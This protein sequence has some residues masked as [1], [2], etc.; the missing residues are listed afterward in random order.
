MTD[1]YKIIDDVYHHPIIGYGSIKSVYKESKSINKYITVNDVKDYLSKLQSKQVQFRYKWY[2]SFVAKDFLEQIQLDIADF[3]KHAEQNDGFRYG[4]AGVDVFSRYGYIVPMK[5]TQPHG[6]I[7][8]FKEIM[9]VIGVP[10]T[11][12]SDL[13]GSMLSND[14]VKR[15]NE[16]NIKHITTLNHAGYAEVFIRTVK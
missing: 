15:S 9:R 4:F 12:F 7:N 2:N 5:T 11:I 10:K 14:F 16:N 3:T 1:K 6:V 8:A 13:D